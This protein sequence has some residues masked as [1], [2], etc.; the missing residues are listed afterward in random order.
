MSE[1]FITCEEESCFTIEDKNESQSE[2]FADL[3]GLTLISLIL[4][5]V[6][7]VCSSLTIFA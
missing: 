5:V 1:R 2:F 6:G 3:F 4:G 7:V